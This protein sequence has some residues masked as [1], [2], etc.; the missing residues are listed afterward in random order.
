MKRGASTSNQGVGNVQKLLP[1]AK[2]KSSKDPSQIVVDES[3]NSRSKKA[4]NAKS[5]NSNDESGFIKGP[6]RRKLNALASGS[7]IHRRPLS[8]HQ[9]STSAAIAPPGASLSCSTFSIPQYSRISRDNTRPGYFSPTADGHGADIMRSLRFERRADPS[10]APSRPP[11]AN[12]R[13]NGMSPVFQEAQPVRQVAQAGNMTPGGAHGTR[14]REPYAKHSLHNVQS[15][16]PG[17]SIVRRRNK[18]RSSSGAAMRMRRLPAP[19]L[20]PRE[21]TDK[22][23][24]E[25]RLQQYILTCE[26][27]GEAVN[28]E[29]V[30]AVQEYLSSDTVNHVS[31]EDPNNNMNYNTVSCEESFQSFSELCFPSPPGTG[32]GVTGGGHASPSSVGSGLTPSPE[33]GSMG[34]IGQLPLFKSRVGNPT[35][36]AGTGA[37]G[38]TPPSVAPGSPSSKTNAGGSKGNRRGHASTPS[39]GMVVGLGGNVGTNGGKGEGGGDITSWAVAEAVLEKMAAFCRQ[40]S[41]AVRFKR[42]VILQ[43]RQDVA[44]AVQGFQQLYNELPTAYSASPV[45]KQKLQGKESTKGKGGT[46][47]RHF[48]LTPG[49]VPPSEEDLLK[50][51]KLK[52]DAEKLTAGLHTLQLAVVQLLLRLQDYAKEVRKPLGVAACSGQEIR[53]ENWKSPSCS[54]NL[55]NTSLSALMLGF[56]GPASISSMSNASTTPAHFQGGQK[57]SNTDQDTTFTSFADFVSHQERE[58][59]QQLR[60]VQTKVESMLAKNSLI[61]I[62]DTSI[63]QTPL[64]CS[65]SSLP[66][67]P[68]LSAS[69]S[70]IGK[71]TGPHDVLFQHSRPVVSK[72]TDRTL[73]N[74]LTSSAPLQGKLAGGQPSGAIQQPLIPSQLEQDGSSVLRGGSMWC[75]LFTVATTTGEGKPKKYTGLQEQLDDTAAQSQKKKVTLV[76]SSAAQSVPSSRMGVSPL[77]FPDIQSPSRTPLDSPSAGK[78]LSMTKPKRSGSSKHQR[79]SQ[80]ISYHGGVIAAEGSQERSVSTSYR[81]GSASTGVFSLLSK[82]QLEQARQ[83]WNVVSSHLA[84]EISDTPQN[85][86]EGD[87]GSEKEDVKKTSL[88]K[89]TCPDEVLSEGREASQHPSEHDDCAPFDERQ[90]DVIEENKKDHD[91]SHLA[92]KKKAPTSVTTPHFLISTSHMKAVVPEGILRSPEAHSKKCSGKKS[93]ATSSEEKKKDNANRTLP[94]TP[95]FPESGG[96]KD[97]G[98]RL[99]SGKEQSSFRS[100]HSA[101]RADAPVSV[102]RQLKD[103]SILSGTSMMSP[104]QGHQK[105]ATQGNRSAQASKSGSSRNPASSASLIASTSPRSKV[106]SHTTSPRTAT[107]RPSEKRL[108]KTSKDVERVFEEVQRRAATLLAAWWRGCKA[109][110]EANLRKLH[111]KN[112]TLSFQEQQRRLVAGRCILRLWNQSKC[113][114]QL[115]KMLGKNTSSFLVDGGKSSPISSASKEGDGVAQLSASRDRFLRAKEQRRALNAELQQ[116]V[117]NPDDTVKN[118]GTNTPA[119]VAVAG[120]KPGLRVA[121]SV[122]DVPSVPPVAPLPLREMGI[123]TT[124]IVHYNNDSDSFDL[125]VLHRL[126]RAP[127]TL[128]Y[129]LCMLTMKNPHY[130][131]MGYASMR[132]SNTPSFE[133]LLSK[134]RNEHSIHHPRGNAFTTIIEKSIP[135]NIR[136]IGNSFLIPYPQLKKLQPPFVHLIEEG[137]TASGRSRKA[138][139]VGSPATFISFPWT[140]RHRSYVKPNEL[141]SA[142]PVVKDFK[143]PFE[144]WGMSN[145]FVRRLFTA[146]AIYSWKLIFSHTP[147][148]DFK[149]RQLQNPDQRAARLDRVDQRNRM[150][151]ACYCVHSER[152][153]LREASKD[154]SFVGQLWNPKRSLDQNDP[155]LLRHAKET[156]DFVEDFIYQCFPTVSG[157]DEVPSFLLG[158]GIFFLL[159]ESLN[160]NESILISH[161]IPWG[162]EYLTKPSDFISPNKKKE[163]PLSSYAQ[164]AQLKFELCDLLDHVVK[165]ESRRYQGKPTKIFSS[166][167]LSPPRESGST[168]SAASQQ[169]KTR[170][171]SRGPISL[172]VPLHKLVAT[173]STPLHI[174]GFSSLNRLPRAKDSNAQGGETSSKVEDNEGS[175]LKNIALLRVPVSPTSVKMFF[176]G[177]EESLLGHSMYW[178]RQ[179]KEGSVPNVDSENDPNNYLVIY[180]R[181]YLVTLSQ[182]IAKV[183]FGLQLDLD[184]C[185][186]LDCLD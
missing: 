25:E 36:T 54:V 51:E 15:S 33:L 87:G 43:K 10:P 105:E 117:K 78:A 75:P 89:L 96:R 149:Q 108:S 177:F 57:D 109:R 83:V 90:K 168:S 46:K 129:M 84:S 88:Q 112:E 113:R 92:E 18:E 106:A 128:L 69:S 137:E 41:S 146:A 100:S 23:E 50:L 107:L 34:K 52:G 143:R 66:T 59:A 93:E 104:T 115:K 60:D 173:Q 175:Y 71:T 70:G 176:R 132:D 167:S 97:G 141:R 21:P 122:A 124:Q 131:P 139:E 64:F 162:H 157:L 63:L 5:S 42:D 53:N 99:P 76:L 151:L 22:R 102:T 74:S 114:K 9:S 13:K 61:T 77:L 154:I 26:S 150:I 3:T 48:S 40:R 56:G 94:P 14:S 12:P 29:W 85:E 91:T 160:Y 82:T 186:E 172:E 123:S 8:A 185:E 65:R 178:V 166:S 155:D 158:A 1:P 161:L 80:S 116:E 120:V 111:R 179:C 181:K 140:P 126:C 58:I 148:D 79:R 98:K 37:Q 49:D 20:K 11:R 159:R 125:R 30:N 27:G 133:G 170:I 136:G 35:T 31:R 68:A 62:E 147:H 44:T 7:H 39:S 2:S 103:K 45:G 19:S 86:K 135:D 81:V 47:S 32:G 72:A 182:A 24:M 17:A 28:E 67:Q 38:A 169:H 153:W 55:P 142:H 165:E 119:S 184:V 6:P 110:H 164:A 118:G 73:G 156:F 183:L 16:D 171:R 134:V 174:F 121:I 138:E 145:A 130:P 144:R 101:A 127:T 180:P 152:E 95:T 163:K 4:E